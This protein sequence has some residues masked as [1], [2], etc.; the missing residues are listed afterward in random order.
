MKKSV[1]ILLVLFATL[2]GCS[3][4]EESPPSIITHV[5]QSNSYI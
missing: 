3:A 4:K 5:D 2:S 1:F